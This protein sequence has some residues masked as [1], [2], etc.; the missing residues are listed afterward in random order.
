MADEFD[1]ARLWGDGRTDRV[2]PEVGRDRATGCAGAAAQVAGFRFGKLESD[3]GHIF[4]RGWS[5]T[6]LRQ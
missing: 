5:I 3:R 2:C 4:E 6:L 1:F